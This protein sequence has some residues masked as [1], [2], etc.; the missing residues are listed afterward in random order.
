MY[1]LDP[2][3][4]TK[5]QAHTVSTLP[6][7][8]PE[9]GLSEWVSREFG[10]AP[11]GDRR[12]SVRLEKTAAML[13]DVLGEGI[14]RHTDYELADVRGCYRLLSKEADSPVTLEN[15]FLFALHEASQCLQQALA[16]LI[17]N[18]PQGPHT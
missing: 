15:I 8:Q 4:R 9:E 11:L 2:D 7:R 14:A 10:G 5:L 13:N 18:C 3:W 1:E 6:V 12:L 17:A 16:E